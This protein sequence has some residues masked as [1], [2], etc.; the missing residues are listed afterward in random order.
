MSK[1]EGVVGA[2]GATPPENAQ[3][4]Q[5]KEYREKALTG[6]NAFWDPDKEV[7][8]FHGKHPTLVG[9]EAVVAVDLPSFLNGAGQI[10]QMFVAP[11]LIAR[12]EA[13]KAVKG[14][15]VTS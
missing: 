3:A 14:P 10:V 2:I 8:Y 7:F 1:K 6:D 4:A 9:V 11:L 5:L 15:K 12:Q 13:M